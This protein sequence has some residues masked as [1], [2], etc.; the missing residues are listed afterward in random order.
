MNKVKEK[1]IEE[2]RQTIGDKLFEELMAINPEELVKPLVKLKKDEEI[3]SH[4]NEIEKKAY[5]LIAKKLEEIRAP[6]IDLGVGQ[7][8]IN[9][10]KQ[11]NK[12]ID[13][14]KDFLWNS[15]EAK[16]VRNKKIS[17]DDFINLR[18]R[19]HFEV[20]SRGY[21]VDCGKC[22][23]QQNCNGFDCNN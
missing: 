4:L 11:L 21:F 14:C 23:E 15:V 9:V 13:T 3:L 5:A 2:A 6:Y 17:Q 18:L 22:F 20:V 7:E 19:K 8:A 16:L 12:E 1:T 10:R